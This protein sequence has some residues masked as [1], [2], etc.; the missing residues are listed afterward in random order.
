M[1]KFTLYH[2]YNMDNTIIKS[3]DLGVQIDPGPNPGPITL[4]K[5]Y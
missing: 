3:V 4:G 2:L 5:L 1:F